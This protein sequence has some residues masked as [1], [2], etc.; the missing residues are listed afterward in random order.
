MDVDDVEEETVHA[1]EIK[2][3]HEEVW[4]R[5]KSVLGSTA[6]IFGMLFVQ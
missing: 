6:L 2:L 1:H 5:S 3:I 4:L